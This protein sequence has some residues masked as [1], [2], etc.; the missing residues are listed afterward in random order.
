MFSIL[1]YVQHRQVSLVESIY[2][3]TTFL[4]VLC[5]ADLSTYLSIYDSVEND[6]LNFLVLNNGI[7]AGHLAVGIYK[8]R[9]AESF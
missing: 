9:W 4:L 3:L 8:A 6:G 5:K 1:C 7:I 2:A